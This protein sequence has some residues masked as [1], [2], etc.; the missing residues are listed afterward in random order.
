MITIA[1][2]IEE[3]VRRVMQEVYSGRKLGAGYAIPDL[4]AKYEGYRVIEPDAVI[5]KRIADNYAKEAE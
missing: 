5:Y 3:C 2:L 4:V 1:E